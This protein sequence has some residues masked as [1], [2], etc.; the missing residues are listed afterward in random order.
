M[1]LTQKLTLAALFVLALNLRH[2]VCHSRKN[3][4]L[5]QR[6]QAPK[7]VDKYGSQEKQQMLSGYVMFIEKSKDVR[8]LRAAGDI[9]SADLENNA[10]L[11]EETQC[12]LRARNTTTVRQKSLCPWRYDVKYRE[13]RF[14]EFIS[15]AKCTC[16]TCNHLIKDQIPNMYGCLPIMEPVPAL[17]RTCGSDGIYKWTPQIEFISIGCTCALKYSIN[18]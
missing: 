16:S 11:F 5:I 10:S 18:I 8:N 14:P 4:P 6:L 12:L 1:F 7:C 2:A 9:L 15:E 17:I 3:S 13:D